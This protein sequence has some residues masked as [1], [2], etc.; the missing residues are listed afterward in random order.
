MGAGARKAWREGEQWR[1]KGRAGE[2]EKTMDRK[3]KRAEQER[4][5]G[6]RRDGWMERRQQKREKKEENSMQ[7]LCLE[8]TSSKCYRTKDHTVCI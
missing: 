5:R 8:E 4:G 2:K 1:E 7:V 3:R 6:A